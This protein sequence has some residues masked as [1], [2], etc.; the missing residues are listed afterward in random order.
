M[1]K[2]KSIWLKI[3]NFEYMFAKDG[4]TRD[5]VKARFYNSKAWRDCAKA[6][7]QSRCY[8]CERCGNRNVNYGFKPYEKQFHVHHKIA[9]TDENISNPDISLNWDNL[10][11]LCQRCHDIEHY[12]A[13]CTQEGLMF[14]ENGDLVKK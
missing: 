2:D 13:P 9:L 10:E 6:Y 14:N 12:G 4:E 1:S 11:L 3:Q 7:A 8:I 5:P